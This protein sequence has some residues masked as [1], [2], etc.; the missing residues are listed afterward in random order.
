[1]NSMSKSGF[2]LGGEVSNR[3]DASAS[4]LLARLTTA[5]LPADFLPSQVMGEDLL[6]RAIR[7]HVLLGNVNR[8][9]PAAGASR[10][11]TCCAARQQQH[12]A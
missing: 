6:G 9:Q 7:E 5:S 11:T 10:G 1:M 3:L 12:Q 4:P 2:T 8:L